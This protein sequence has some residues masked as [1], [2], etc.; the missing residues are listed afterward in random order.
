MINLSY[1]LIL[2]PYIVCHFSFWWSILVLFGS[3]VALFVITIFVYDIIKIDWLLIEALKE[4]QEQSTTMEKQNPITKAIGKWANKG[5]YILLIFFL[6][7]DPMVVVL[8]YRNGYYLYNGI[9]TPR[10]WI[11]AVLSSFLNNLLA[12]VV[13]SGF[14]YG[15]EFLKHFF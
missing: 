12:V 1:G 2:C 9:R 10:V 15:L 13:L 11:L 4:A 5:R 14:F 6:F 8:Y 7:W 3:S